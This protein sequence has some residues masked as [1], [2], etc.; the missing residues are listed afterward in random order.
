MGK[1]LKA[2]SRNIPWLEKT[3]VYCWFDL[4]GAGFEMLNMIRQCYRNAASFLM[5]DTTLKAF[6]RFTVANNPKMKIL[7]YLMPSERS[8]YHYMV[9][10][11]LR[12]EQERISQRFVQQS[13]ENFN[14]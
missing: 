9:S 2:V 13:V 3:D 14:Q 1:G 10:Q 6:E 7:N 5:D 8:L 11:K 4:D 12:L